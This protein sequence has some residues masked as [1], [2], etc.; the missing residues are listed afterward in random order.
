M[1]VAV[2]MGLV[3]LLLIIYPFLEQKFTGDTAHHNLLQRPRDV[4]VRTYRRY[5]DRVPPWC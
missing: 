2:I 1:W 4:P 5:G 3:F